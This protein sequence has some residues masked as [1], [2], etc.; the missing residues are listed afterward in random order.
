MM[1]TSIATLLL[2]QI[3][4][5]EWG[6]KKYKIYTI[7]D[8]NGHQLHNMACLCDIL[9]HSFATISKIVCAPENRIYKGCYRFIIENIIAPT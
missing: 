1:H 4:N 3:I 8:V 5:S 9:S 2:I 6:E 7:H